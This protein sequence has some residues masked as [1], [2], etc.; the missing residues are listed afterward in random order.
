MKAMRRIVVGL[1]VV[2]MVLSFAACGGSEQSVILQLTDNL[3]W[4][5]VIDTYSKG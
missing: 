4:V 5:T 2:G 1:L 3:T